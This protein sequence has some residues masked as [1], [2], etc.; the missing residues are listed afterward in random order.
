MPRHLTALALALPA[1]V[2]LGC[3]KPDL[4]VTKLRVG[5]TRKEVL[6]RAGGPTRT[7]VTN[8]TEVLEYE[9]YDRYGAIKINNRTQYVRLVNGRVDAFGTL[10]DLKAGRPSPRAQETRLKASPTA[11]E[12]G[13][14]ERAASPA[15]LA[16]DLRTE[17]E[18]LEKLKK[19]GLI[20]ETEFQELRQKVMDKARAQ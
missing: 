5:M 20:S 12:G 6:E 17:L 18:K 16:F 3:T 10:E 15:A 9:A 14:D 8:D 4:D 11:R 13:A 7:T 2:S 19:D 1:L